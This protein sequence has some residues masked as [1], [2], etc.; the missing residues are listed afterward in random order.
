[1]LLFTLKAEVI[2]IGELRSNLAIVQVGLRA[3]VAAVLLTAS[4]SDHWR[5]PVHILKLVEA[6]RPAVVVG[7]DLPGVLLLLL[8]RGMAVVVSS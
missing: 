7:A 3:L 2:L 4:A 6:A 1:M 8:L 5:A